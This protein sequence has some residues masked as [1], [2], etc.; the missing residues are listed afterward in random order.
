MRPAALAALAFALVAA[1]AGAQEIRTQRVSFPPGA[2]SATYTGVIRGRE[3]VDYLVNARAGQV[4]NISMA[5]SN[6]FAYFNITAPGETEV[7]FHVGS[8]VGNQFEGRLPASGDYRI[9]VY[10]MRNA[11]RRGETADYR[12]EM[13]IPAGG[14]ATQSPERPPA[15]FVEG[16]FFEVTGVGGGDSLNLRDGPSTSAR[17]VGRLSN[18]AVLRNVGGCRMTGQTRWCNV[19]TTGGARVRGWVLARYLREPRPSGGGAATQLPAQPPA[20]GQAGDPA[21][22]AADCQRR[23]AERL[24]VPR[25]SVTTRAE[26]RRTDGTYP[27]NGSARN[28]G[29]RMVTFQCNYAR[30]GLTF[31]GLTV[32]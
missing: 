15:G 22:L 21:V 13:I 2:E 29:G 30:D 19:E 1:A 9:R 20:G 24:G 10:L 17:I 32:N 11:A 4:A 27:V 3:I 18:G 6:R 12:L 5:T 14:T 25:S 8:V 31:T 28:A 23:A 7:A 26:G 16:D